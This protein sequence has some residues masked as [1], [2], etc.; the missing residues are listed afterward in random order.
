MLDA[1]RLEN[2]GDLVRPGRHA[3][4]DLADDRA[5]RK[6]AARTGWRNAP[7]AAALFSSPGALRE[8]RDDMGTARPELKHDLSALRRESIRLALYRAGENPLLAEAAFE[9][10]FAERQRVTLFD[11][12]LPAL[13]FL[14]ARFPLVSAVQR[15]RGPGAGRP[16]AF[17]RASISAREF[18]VGKPDPRIFHRGRRRGG[19][20]AGTC[21][22]RGR[23]R[24]ARCARRAQCRHAGGVAEPRRPPLAARGDAAVRAH[25]WASSLDG[26][27][28]RA[29]CSAAPCSAP[30]RQR[31]RAPRPRAWRGRALRR[32]R[33]RPTAPARSRSA[34]AAAGHAGEGG[35]LLDHGL[36]RLH[37][38]A[39]RRACA[40]TSRSRAPSRVGRAHDE[41]QQPRRSA[42][43]AAV[44][45]ELRRAP[46]RWRPA[47]AGQPRAALT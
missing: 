39:Q 16:R 3:L 22:A 28:L 15:Q 38:P 20:A 11:D 1:R 47:W 12:A 8:I 37:P 9:V 36:H 10:F 33:R 19:H 24:H 45:H 6:G 23:R 18:G 2:Q 34:G 25:V 5:R 17:F 35:A 42:Q 29:R 14:S 43:L 4:A 31:R 32:S 7:M 41:G 21:P 30:R 46:R 27:T 40:S 44:E 26:V 13:E